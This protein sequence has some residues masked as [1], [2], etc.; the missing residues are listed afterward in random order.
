VLELVLPPPSDGAGSALPTDVE[1]EHKEGA[2]EVGSLFMHYL[3]ICP[4]D[5]LPPNESSLQSSA[6]SSSL[7][8][9]PWSWSSVLH[10]HFAPVD[11]FRRT[12]QR[13]LEMPVPVQSLRLWSC[14]KCRPL[15]LDGDHSRLLVEVQGGSVLGLGSAG[16]PVVNDAG[17][18]VAMQLCSYRD[19][20][21]SHKDHKGAVAMSSSDSLSEGSTIAVCLLL[22]QIAEIVEWQT[23]LNLPLSIDGSSEV[24]P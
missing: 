17:Q 5:R 14:F 6:P 21:G 19:V 2:G 20:N 7:S 11:W 1:D 18:V 10:L 16:A 3:P 8:L 23:S 13:L 12:G 24:G 22:G 4:A 9:V 15:Q